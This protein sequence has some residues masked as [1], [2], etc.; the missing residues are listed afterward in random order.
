[1]RLP[2]VQGCIYR[3]SL[4]EHPVAV[5]SIVPEAGFF[6]DFGEAVNLIAGKSNHYSV[7]S[8]EPTQ[9]LHFPERIMLVAAHTEAERW[10]HG[11]DDKTQVSEPDTGDIRVV[12]LYLV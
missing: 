10:C 7:I 2:S 9:A 8:V 6:V 11:L 3:V 12:L 4:S 5:P 1:M